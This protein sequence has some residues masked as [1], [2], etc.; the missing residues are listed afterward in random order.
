MAAAA[1]E[2]Y[3]ALQG[4][5]ATGLKFDNSLVSVMKELFDSIQ[6]ASEDERGLRKTLEKKD[7]EVLF[8]PHNQHLIKN[9]IGNRYPVKTR[10]RTDSF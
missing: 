8:L 6:T 2:K 4:L 9:F 7:D 1:Q 10:F 3:D 5:I